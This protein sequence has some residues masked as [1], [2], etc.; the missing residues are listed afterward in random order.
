MTALL[1]ALAGALIVAGVIG[2]AVGLRPVPPRATAPST[3]RPGVRRVTSMSR[4]TRMLLLAGTA[5]GLLVAVA[6]GWLVAVLVVPA[7]AAGLPV[8]LSAP[9]ASARID[10]LEAMEEWTRSLSGVLTAGV[11]LE[12]ALIATLRSTPDPIRPEVTRLASRL[13]AR[14]T[15]EDALR[16]FADD[17]DDATGDVVA[18]NLILGARRRGAGLASVLDALAESVAADV[19]A[20]REIEADRAKPRATARWVT[21]ITISV[22]AF[23]ALTGQ[24]VAP[25]G[26]PLGQVLLVL[27]LS[28]Y[29]ATLVWMR[30]MTTGTPLPRFVGAAARAAAS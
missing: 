17:L 8:L 19:R 30:R 28:L 1:P 20:R 22:L 3:P 2:V 9:P 25:F 14:W 15:T 27:L 11:G 29:V 7:A 6:T 24:Y 5:T 12:Q 16:A 18:A 23:L 10:R 21:L 4:R 26:T 13:R